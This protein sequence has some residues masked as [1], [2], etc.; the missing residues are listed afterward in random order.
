[1]H[2]RRPSIVRTG[3]LVGSLLAGLAGSP[4][5]Q[6]GEV[7]RPSPKATKQSALPPGQVTLLT[8]DRV[9]IGPTGDVQITPGAGRKV[10]FEQRTGKDQLFVIPSDVARDVASGRLDR[11]LFDVAG[12]IRQGLD[13][14]TT[15]EIPL[16]VTYSQKAKT[17][18]LAGAAVTRQ[19]PAVNGS[20]VK[21]GKGSAK[22]FL[23]QLSNARAASGIEK[24]WLDRKLKPALDQ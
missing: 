9:T 14:R 11:A 5:A 18:A 22:T 6:A 21:V 15:K 23:T 3:V 17:S 4:P 16:I 8:G 1:M 2:N 19:L 7:S 12:Q 10:Q 24:V 13:D 20:A